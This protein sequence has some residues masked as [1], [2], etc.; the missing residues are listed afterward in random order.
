LPQ[1][2]ALLP[3]F[4]VA[5][6]AV[7]LN[8]CLHNAWL[9]ITQLL[10]MQLPITQLFVAQRSIMRL[11]LRSVFT[12]AVFPLRILEPGIFERRV[13]QSLLCSGRIR[14][15]AHVDVARLSAACLSTTWS[16]PFPRPRF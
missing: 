5:E 12:L 6:A 1:G 11:C 2:S 3:A 16:W 9:P 13:L 4:S 14:V 10:V 15:V 8:A 7:S